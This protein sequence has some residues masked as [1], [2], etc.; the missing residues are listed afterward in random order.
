CVISQAPAAP[1]IIGAATCTITPSGQLAP[2]GFSVATTAT[3]GAYTITV[4]GTTGDAASATFT[5]TASAPFIVPTPNAAAIG[6]HI[7]VTGGGFNSG[8]VGTCIFDQAPASPVIVASATC[9]I[10]SAGQLTGS[11]FTVA[12]S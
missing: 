5:V 11:G 8:D 6:G 2:S 3:P 12:T 4:T 1:V 10:T 9:S 7:A